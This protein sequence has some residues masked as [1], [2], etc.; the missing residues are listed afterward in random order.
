MLIHSVWNSVEHWKISSLLRKAPSPFKPT[1]ASTLLVS[2][3]DIWPIVSSTLMIMPMDWLLCFWFWYFEHQTYQKHHIIICY[4]ILFTYLYILWKDLSY[5]SES[6]VH[7]CSRHGSSLEQCGSQAFFVSNTVGGKL[8][9]PS[10]FAV[11]RTWRNILGN[12]SAVKL[13]GSLL[14][15]DGVKQ[16]GIP[17]FGLRRLAFLLHTM[18][19]NEKI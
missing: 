5:N 10:R 1:Q 18:G 8:G 4:R 9:L 11:R 2:S 7:V 3:L 13:L 19:P 6:T 16:Q 15:M 14:H 12:M 17:P